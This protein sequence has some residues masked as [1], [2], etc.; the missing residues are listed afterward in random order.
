[1]HCAQ[2]GRNT[3]MHEHL[4]H[5]AEAYAYRIRTVRCSR[6]E[7]ALPLLHEGGTNFGREGVPPTVV[8]HPL[9]R[10]GILCIR[11]KVKRPEQPPETYRSPVHAAMIHTSHVRRGRAH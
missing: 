10:P 3:V 6:C 8:P 5:L 7:H 9:V 2:L 11:V 1:M 4:H